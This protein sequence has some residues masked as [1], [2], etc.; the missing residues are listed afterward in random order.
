MVNKEVIQDLE[1]IMKMQEV[2][3]SLSN[4]AEEDYKTLYDFFKW[5]DDNR[6]LYYE[7]SNKEIIL[8]YLK[9]KGS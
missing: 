4:K 9:H 1:S 6:D 5:F 2:A 8:K 7:I 3:Q